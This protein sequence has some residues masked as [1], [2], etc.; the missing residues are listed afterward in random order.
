VGSQTQEP[1]EGVTVSVPSARTGGFTDFEGKYLIPNLPVGTYEVIIQGIGY[2]MDTLR[3]VMVQANKTTTLNHLILSEAA[4]L[5]GVE[6]KVE[7]TVENTD[8]SLLA[9]LKTTSLVASGISAQ[10]IALSQDRNAA[11]VVRRV[12]GITISEDRF[13]NIRGLSDRYN[14]VMLNSILAPSTETD[15]RA[16][17]FN[18]VP[19][20][21][22]ERMMIYK[23]MAP[24]FYADFGGGVVKIQT[25]NV[26]DENELSIGVNGFWRVGSTATEYLS[27]Q[28]GSEVLWGGLAAANRLPGSLAANLSDP[29]ITNAQRAA[30]GR[31]FPNTWGTETGTTM[32]DGNL[33]LTF[34]RRFGSRYIQVGQITVLT[35][36]QTATN[37]A[38]ERN[39]VNVI[40]DANTGAG[41]ITNEYNFQDQQFTRNAGFNALHNW[42]FRIGDSHKLEFRNLFNRQTQYQTTDRTG[43]IFDNDNIIREVSMYLQQR[44]LYS[45]QLTG[46]HDVAKQRGRLD[47][48]L[49]YSVAQKQEPDF[50][51]ARFQRFRSEP[52]SIMPLLVEL[53]PNQRFNSRFYSQ[54][55]ENITTVAANYAHK[56]EA[57]KFRAQLKAGTYL[58]FK[59]RS[60]DARVF[61]V[62]RG[63]RQRFDNNLTLLPLNEVFDSSYFRLP[64]GFQMSEATNST[65]RFNAQNRLLSGYLAIELPFLSRFK[66]YTGVRYENNLQRLQ[67]RQVSGDSVDVRSP[68]AFFLPSANLTCNLSDRNLI[69]LAYGQ[70]VNRPEFRELAPFLFF[71]FDYNA[72]IVGNPN[73]KTAE[74]RHLD[75]RWEFYPTLSELIS[76]AAFGK[77]FTNPIEQVSIIGT[78]GRIFNTANAPS[79]YVVGLELELRKSL[80]FIAPNSVLKYFSAQFNGSLIH[81]EVRF[82]ETQAGALGTDKRPLQGQAPYVINTGLYFT[83]P[84]L[85]FQA[86]IQYNVVGPTIQIAGDAYDLDYFLLPQNTIDLTLTKTF[87]TKWQVTLGI[88]NLLDAPYVLT[89]DTN[90]DGKHRA[91]GSDRVFVKFNR[92]QYVN[93]G[94]RYRF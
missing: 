22:L 63:N 48:T 93:L 84:E 10:Q 83:H 60:F 74:I 68:F 80:S 46:T 59:D 21:M 85:D 49:G 35:A 23:T 62:I 5:E 11:Q 19:S 64:D 69:R 30:F 58:E 43:Y 90:L 42:S 70:T 27:Q 45:G 66:L 57:G 56:I 34:A 24:E 40:T 73:L 18:T 32:P 77:Q 36:S 65:F 72:S 52:D 89:Q 14:I 20:S 79:A 9:D 61:S 39:R 1:V 6:I 88:Q 44:W 4:E 76:L 2:R 53:A 87:A 37:Y 26:P 51:R 29:T 50:R 54:N 16:F 13:I 31:L 94:L 25:R 15:R 81:S 17:S 8:I 75:L 78:S 55:N 92:G 7:K 71:D 86:S 12:P 47:W 41:E 67:S 82:T 33:N 28:L 91:D 38:I 3:N